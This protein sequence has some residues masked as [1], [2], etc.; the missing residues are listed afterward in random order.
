M[1][2]LRSSMLRSTSDTQLAQHGEGATTPEP[3]LSKTTPH[4]ARFASLALATRLTAAAAKQAS[5]SPANGSGNSN[6]TNNPLLGRTQ[7]QL[8]AEDDPDLLSTQTPLDDVAIY[9]K[10]AHFYRYDGTTLSSTAR[11]PMREYR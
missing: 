1:K 11:R 8:L 3:L 5:G 2:T 6:N 10:D 7:R 9:I 4:H